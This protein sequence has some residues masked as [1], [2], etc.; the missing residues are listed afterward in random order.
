MN[1]PRRVVGLLAIIVGVLAIAGTAAIPLTNHPEFC[2][3]CHTIRPS[4]ES[5]KQSSHKEVTCVD[6]HVRPGLSGFLQDKVLAG[7]KDVTITFF[8]TPTEPHNLQATVDSAICLG[9]H[10]AILRV[11]EISVRD[12]PGPVKQVGL[13]MSHRQHMEAFA[14]RNQGE[15]C[16][17]CHNRVVHS[18]PIKGYP[19]VIP[20]G[21][22]KLDMKPYY[23]DYPE[24]SRLW[25]ATLQDCMRCHD[26]KT[27][28]NGKVLSKKCETCHLPEKL[29]EFL[30]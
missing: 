17:T 13:I 19:I 27:T 14:K 12:L 22:V 4:V 1:S 30:F 29:R 23:P 11:S 9:C 15:G 16:T 5:W 25:N 26:G 18:T 10:R 21:H 2:A 28:Y 6:C 24:G 20:R 3:S 7:I 8:G